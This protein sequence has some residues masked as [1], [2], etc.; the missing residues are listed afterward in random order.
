MTGLNEKHLEGIEGRGISVEIATRMGLYSGKRLPD[1]SVAPDVNGNVLC[2]PFYEGIDEVN[3]KYRWSEGGVRKFMQIPGRPKT[4]FNANA[5]MDDEA[6]AILEKGE[7]SLVITEGE[8]DAMAAI[9]AGWWAAMS[10]PNGAT[11][12][13]RD[14]DGKLIHVPEDSR[15]IDPDQDQTFQYLARHEERLSKVKIFVIATDG[16]EPG[17]R[18]AKELVRRIGAARCRWVDYPKDPVVQDKKTGEMRGCKD[19]NEVLQHFGQGKVQELIETAPAWPVKGLYKFS[20]FPDVGE[21]VTYRTGLSDDLDEIFR[22]YPG[23]FVVVTGIPNMGKALALDTPVPTPSG[24]T[25]M[26]ELKVGD[27]VFDENGKPCRVIAVTDVLHDR[28]VY[29]MRF[30]NGEEVLADANHLWLT[31]AEKARR[32]RQPSNRMVPTGPSVVTTR[33]ISMTLVS[34]GKT[35]HQ[36]P[37]ALAIKGTSAILPLDPYTLGAWLG[38]GRTDYAA[39]TAFDEEVVEKIAANGHTVRPQAQKG[40]YGILGVLPAM[41]E[42]GVLGNKHIPALYLR[43]SVAQRFELLKG[44]MDTDGHCDLNRNC[45]FATTDRRLAEDVYELVSGL[46][47]KARSTRG[48]AK[49]NGTVVSEK[50]RIRFVSEQPVFAMP[51]KLARQKAGTARRNPNHA[52]VACDLV[53]SVPVRCIQ[54]DSPS[55]LFLATRSFI[56]THNSEIVKQIAVNMAKLHGWHC[57]MFPGEEPVKPYLENSLRTKYL[58]KHRS[59]WTSGDRAEANDFLERHFEIIANDPRHDEEEIDVEYLLDKAATSVFRNGTKLLIIDPW[60]EL[61]HKSSGKHWSQTDYIGDAIRRIK[62]FGRSFDVCTIVVAHPK[63]TDTQPGLYSIS[64]S[65]HWANKADL[66]L[67]VHSDDAFGTL[68]DVIVPKARFSAA[69]RK[70]KVQMEFDRELEL[71]IPVNDL[72]AANDQNAA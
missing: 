38:D 8:F 26:G 15:D 29:R 17:R 43:A 40:Q 24:W 14:K 42:L 3:T 60:N 46:G 11:L 13:A 20:Q 57:V 71:Y 53:K 16:D 47:I 56:P 34:Q 50:F 64:D 22:P 61:E 37:A 52:I 33:E 45:E 44:L 5:I 21:P 35:N 66:G 27:T 36:V 30:D 54:V 55:H 18:L 9:Q 4:F 69:G 70:G 39:I 41:R 28:P 7:M 58:H 63:K 68:R 49:L 2:F 62:R 12:P 65:A 48:D 23:A 25:T 1:G 72:F 19:L 67:V 31:D 6:L 51:R 32:S 59:N 10:V